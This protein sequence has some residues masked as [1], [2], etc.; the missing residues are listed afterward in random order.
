[1]LFYFTLGGWSKGC[2]KAAS[3][4]AHCEM[5][6]ELRRPSSLSNVTSTAM[7][8]AHGHGNKR[9]RAHTRTHT[10]TRTRRDS[11]SRQT[12]RQTDRQTHRQTDMQTKQT[13]TQKRALCGCTH[14]Y[15]VSESMNLTI[16]TR[17]F[18]TTSIECAV[19]AR[20]SIYAKMRRAKIRSQPMQT[21][22]Q[23]R[24]GAGSGPEKQAARASRRV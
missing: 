24:D 1:M 5:S 8:Q 19:P 15:R 23:Q 3:S 9:A 11:D 22:V 4:R 13:D 7:L 2:R 12:D 14:A 18:S 6:S 21:T 20:S 17:A 10:C 16:G